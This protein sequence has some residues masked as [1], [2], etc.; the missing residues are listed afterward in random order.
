MRELVY[1][2]LHFSVSMTDWF[3]C[4]AIICNVTQLAC[5][6]LHRDNELFGLIDHRSIL[7]IVS[8][9]FSRVYRIPIY[10]CLDSIRLSTLILIHIRFFCH[11]TLGHFQILLTYYLVLPHLF[12]LT[13]HVPVWKDEGIRWGQTCTKLQGN[14][15]CA[16]S[17]QTA[18]EHRGTTQNTKFQVDRTIGNGTN[19]ICKIWPAH[20]YNHPSLY[21]SACA[22]AISQTRN[23]WANIIITILIFK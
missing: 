23:A 19:S 14:S 2:S 22:Q 11:L 7:Y 1:I 21:T 18:R 4:P 6:F 9:L 3:H 10:C 16:W 20:T 8:R 15:M 5:K 17:Y 13:F 12:H